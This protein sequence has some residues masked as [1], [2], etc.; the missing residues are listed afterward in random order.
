MRESNGASEQ[1]ELAQQGPYVVI[2]TLRGYIGN[3]VLYQCSAVC[4]QMRAMMNQG[5]HMHEI[6]MPLFVTLDPSSARSG[7]IDALSPRISYHIILYQYSGI[8][9]HTS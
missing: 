7:L 1:G 4:I 8:L 6:W 2:I 5:V 9:L 3:P